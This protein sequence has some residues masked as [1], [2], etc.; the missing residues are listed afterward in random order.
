MK[1]GFLMGLVAGRSVTRPGRAFLW[2]SQDGQRHA[3]WHVYVLIWVAPVVFALATALLA[4]DSW[5]RTH[6]T[7][8]T[9]GEVVRVYEWDGE[10]SP[11]FRYTW[12]DGNETEASTG[13]RD[14]GWNFPVGS[15][16][17]IRYFAEARRDVVLEGPHNWYVA[18]MIGLFTLAAFA[19]AL[20]LHGLLRRWLRRGARPGGPAK[21]GEA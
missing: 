12:T 2:V 21:G 13:Y 4:F 14:A 9:T 11:V 6:G 16:H 17:A 3:S 8:P 19:L 1:P 7:V 20:A 18:R 15:R 5:K 10:Y